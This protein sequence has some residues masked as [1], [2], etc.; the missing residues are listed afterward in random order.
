M[1]LAVSFFYTSHKS[2]QI[3]LTVIPVV[4]K[5]FK[6]IKCIKIVKNSIKIIVKTKCK[7]Y[8]LQCGEISP[9]ESYIAYDQRIQIGLMKLQPSFAQSGSTG[10]RLEIL[11]CIDRAQQMR[12][13]HR[14]RTHPRPEEQGTCGQS[15]GSLAKIETPTLTQNFRFDFGFTSCLSAQAPVIG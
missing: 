11:D 4:F 9:S 6:C 12:L 14:C 10:P 8:L 2:I 3:Y 15:R 5:L 1:K 13:V 7:S